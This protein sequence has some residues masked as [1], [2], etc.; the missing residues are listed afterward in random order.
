MNICL[1]GN[2]IVGPRVLV[3]VEYGCVHAG[4]KLVLVMA[5][6]GVTVLLS[7][8]DHACGIHEG[9]TGEH[10]QALI[11]SAN[12]SISLQERQDFYTSPKGNGVAFVTSLRVAT[13]TIRSNRS[14]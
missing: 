3:S 13:S 6:T 7:I 9:R 11:D 1:A 4:A 2:V 10:F 12:N 8:V 14:G 5:H